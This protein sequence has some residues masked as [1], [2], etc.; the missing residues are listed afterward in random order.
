ML[1]YI[2][3]L[4][5]FALIACSAEEPMIEETQMAQEDVGL[6]WEN[7]NWDTLKGIYRSKTDQADMFL[8]LDFSSPAHLTGYSLYKGLKRNI[9]GALTLRGDSVYIVV[10]EPGD[11]ESDGQFN[12]A[13]NRDNINLEGYWEMQNG[14]KRHTLLFKKQ[15]NSDF[16][17]G[18][19]L[20]KSNIPDYLGY[21]SSKVGELYFEHDGT[22]KMEYYPLVDSGEVSQLE[23]Y[24]GGWTWEKGKLFVDW[25]SNKRMSQPRTPVSVVMNSDGV[26]SLVIDSLVYTA[27][28][29]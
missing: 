20:D 17:W 1:K 13:F 10:S 22:V 6:E 29:W 11:L 5:L 8:R 7:F 12:L 26:D 9:S 25:K 15:D 23:T 2:A 14:K 4:L 19:P 28:Y 3:P 27:R 24:K 21:L 16:E 18:D